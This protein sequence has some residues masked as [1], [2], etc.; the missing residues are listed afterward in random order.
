LDSN[1]TVNAIRQ[2]ISELHSYIIQ[3]DCDISKFNVYV[4]RLAQSLAARNETSQ[5]LLVNIF[6]AYRA[7]RDEDFV[8]YIEQKESDYED[9]SK[10]DHNTLMTM[11]ENKFKN[12]VQKKK[13]CTPSA[14]QNEVVALRAELQKVRKGQKQDNLPSN[15]NGKGRASRE[16]PKWLLEHHAPKQTALDEPR[17]WKNSKYHWC[18]PATGGKCDGAWVRHKPK[19]CRGTKS[20]NNKKGED[21]TKKRKVK[22]NSTGGAK[23]PK[24]QLAKAYSALKSS[25]NVEESS[26]SD[27]D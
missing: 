3:V 5:D 23:H 25:A 7:V 11:A 14:L 4:L 16:K 10:L 9:G 27:Q 26:Q 24:L 21:K 13:W 6:K 17:T 20:K 22:E 1:A 19:E 18:C 8:K 12:L 15:S 2:S